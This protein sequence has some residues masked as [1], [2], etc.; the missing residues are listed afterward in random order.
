MPRSVTLFVMNDLDL[1]LQGHIVFIM[2]FTVNMITNMNRETIF[3]T[4]VHLTLAQTPFEHMWPWKISSRSNYTF[5]SRSS[6]VLIQYIVQ[7]TSWPHYII[8]QYHLERYQKAEGSFAHW[9]FLLKFAIKVCRFIW[10][11]HPIIHIGDIVV[12]HPS[13]NTHWWHWSITSIL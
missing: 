11:I 12:S 8:Y 5:L 9:A 7:D 3:I 2:T 10:I 13:Y 6:T 1:F 4:E